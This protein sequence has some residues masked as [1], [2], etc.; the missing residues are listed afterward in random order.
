MNKVKKI[1]QDRIVDGKWVGARQDG[2]PV[3]KI[4]GEIRD[5]HSV[6]K[7]HGI[8]LS[9]DKY[10]TEHAD[11]GQ[12]SDVRDIEDAGDGVGESQE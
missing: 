4:N 10:R 3:V 1:I 8:K 11:L 2:K 12:T 7:E 5:A 9:K 6:A